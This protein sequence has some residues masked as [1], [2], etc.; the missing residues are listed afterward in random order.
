MASEGSNNLAATSNPAWMLGKKAAAPS[1]LKWAAAPS[2]ELVCELP[3]H[4]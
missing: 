3:P 4:V 1:E 2:Q